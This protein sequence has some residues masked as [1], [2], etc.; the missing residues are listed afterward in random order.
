[1]CTEAKP[2]FP[3]VAV[4][5]KSRSFPEVWPLEWK[6]FLKKPLL[7]MESP[8][9]RRGLA[10]EPLGAFCLKNSLEAALELL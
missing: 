2:L 7:V 5:L 3:E 1:L 9:M 6:V 10:T 8:P 4:A